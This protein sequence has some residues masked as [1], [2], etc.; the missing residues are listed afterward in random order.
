ML[1][2]AHHLGQRE[3]THA[4]VSAGQLR[5]LAGA[6]SLGR[7]WHPDVSVSPV[8]ETGVWPGLGFEAPG[9]A[10]D[11]ATLFPAPDRVA[12]GAWGADGTV[13]LPFPSRWNPN[14]QRNHLIAPAQT[15]VVRDDGGGSDLEVP[16]IRP[17]AC[18]GGVHDEV[19]EKLTGANVYEVGKFNLADTVTL[20]R[21][22]FR[23]IRSLD[24][25]GTDAAA[26]TLEKT[27]FR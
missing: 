25:M 26:G 22:V 8:P 27:G 13:P 18:R 2:G 4:K 15:P 19:P 20:S 12:R 3:V 6:H 11:P 17:L 1:R 14:A 9:G 23:V 5:L 7:I 21:S 16:A 10:A 24:R